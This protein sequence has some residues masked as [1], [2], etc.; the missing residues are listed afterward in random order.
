MIIQ[1]QLTPAVCLLST[2]NSALRTVGTN[3]TA[4]KCYP[5]L[6]VMHIL[7]ITNLRHIPYNI[8]KLFFNNDSC[9]GELVH[10]FHS[11][12]SCFKGLNCIAYTA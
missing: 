11:N 10:K 6:M 7:K 8:F 1:S 5:H 2:A 3:N 4:E 9:Y 12:L